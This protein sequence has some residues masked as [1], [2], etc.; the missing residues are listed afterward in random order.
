MHEEEYDV[1]QDLLNDS[2]SKPPSTVSIDA[3]TFSKFT[4]SKTSC[5]VGFQ[6]S[7]FKS[8]AKL[9]LSKAHSIRSHHIASYL[10]S[11]EW[12]VLA[13]CR[14]GNF[15]YVLLDRNNYVTVQVYTSHHN[16][17]KEDGYPSQSSADVPELYH[18][19]NTTLDS[20][21]FQ[22]KPQD[23]QDSVNK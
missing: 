10:K 6:Q 4:S 18:S 13:N 17:H 11:K 3:R 22:G 20:K 8:S 1:F 9:N 19:F 23:F 15:D 16:D 2:H 7:I 14:N 21:A 5:S 12:R